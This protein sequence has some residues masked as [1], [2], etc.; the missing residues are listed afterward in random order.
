M[1]DLPLDIRIV[2]QKAVIGSA[3]YLK[4]KIFTIIE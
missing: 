1:A 4:V 2:S 3:A